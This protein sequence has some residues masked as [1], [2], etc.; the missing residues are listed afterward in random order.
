MSNDNKNNF[1]V[2]DAKNIF[3]NPKNEL[4]KYL[5]MMDD[6]FPEFMELGRL[7]SKY[8]KERYDS[9]KEEGFSEKEAIE[10]VKSEKTPFDTV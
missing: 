3:S 4:Q 10:I 9:L 5:R 7:K 1:K 6:V 8:N 2:L